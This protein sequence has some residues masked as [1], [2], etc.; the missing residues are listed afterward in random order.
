MADILKLNVKTLLSLPPDGVLNA[1][2][3]QHEKTPF[4]RLLIIGVLKDGQEY[5]A[6]TEA[7][8]SEAFWDIERFKY[9]RLKEGDNESS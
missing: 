8:M 7:D 6:F 1:A 2:L 3:E 9:N 4:K 5:Q